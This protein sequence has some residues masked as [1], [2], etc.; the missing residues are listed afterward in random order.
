MVQNKRIT[1]NKSK[2]LNKVLRKTPLPTTL[3]KLRETQ[4]VL[5]NGGD[6]K[7]KMFLFNLWQTVEIQSKCPR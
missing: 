6:E 1:F 2:V 4:R 7:A 3:H 5:L